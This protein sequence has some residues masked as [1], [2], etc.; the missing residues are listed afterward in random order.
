M[1]T[2]LQTPGKMSQL[3]A[4]ERGLVSVVVPAHNEEG[5]VAAF[6]GRTAKASAQ[7]GRPWELVNVAERVDRL[8]RRMTAPRS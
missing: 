5:T 2:R 1:A 3:Q 4:A 6:V 8:E 7:I